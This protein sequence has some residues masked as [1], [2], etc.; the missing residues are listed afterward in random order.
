MKTAMFHAFENAVSK[1]DKTLT[2]SISEFHNHL[3]EVVKMLDRGI[4]IDLQ[5]Q[6]RKVGMIV[7]Y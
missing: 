4:Y 3:K 7:P 5:A 6:G 2:L 1:N